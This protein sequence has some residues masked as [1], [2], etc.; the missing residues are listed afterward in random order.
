MA[1]ILSLIR[2]ARS[3]KPIDL[4]MAL[5]L[6]MVLWISFFWSFQ[7]MQI[8]KFRNTTSF[9]NHDTRKLRMVEETLQVRLDPDRSESSESIN[10]EPDAY[11][12]PTF[13]FDRRTISAIIRTNPNLLETGMKPVDLI[14]Q[15]FRDISAKKLLSSTDP[16]ALVRQVCRT[17][18]NI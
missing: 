15:P 2:I 3:R 6:F 17:T 12:P 13:R 5:R 11:G 14:E 7:E 4:F 18:S 1:L 16:K 10:C 9:L 8:L